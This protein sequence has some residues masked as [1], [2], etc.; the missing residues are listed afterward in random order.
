MLDVTL[1]APTFKVNPRVKA[2]LRPR[3]NTATS[4]AGNS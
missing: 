3:T 4:D 1:P 2:T